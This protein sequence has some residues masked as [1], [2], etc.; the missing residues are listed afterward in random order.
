MDACG[1]I[2][3][4][5]DAGFVDFFAA[6]VFC[7]VQYGYAPG[8]RGST[9]HTSAWILSAMFF[10]SF[11]FCHDGLFEKVGDRFEVDVEVQWMCWFF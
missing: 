3:V 2:L 9:V 5:V 8:F 6:L 7:R 1:W 4:L 10:F 11:C